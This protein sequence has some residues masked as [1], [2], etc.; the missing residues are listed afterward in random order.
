[1]ERD[2]DFS[3]KG[4]NTDAAMLENR[5]KSGKKIDLGDSIIDY[6]NSYLLKRFI[7]DRGKLNPARITRLS[8][9]QQRKLAKEVKRARHLALIPYCPSHRA[10]RNAD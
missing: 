4:E 9:A 10:A 3:K 1:M 5:F 2:R 7:T 8:A 6:K